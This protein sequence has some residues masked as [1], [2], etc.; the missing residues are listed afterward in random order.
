[1][2]KYFIKSQNMCSK[3]RNA[4][5]VSEI[6]ASKLMTSLFN[7]FTVVS[8]RHSSMFYDHSNN[9]ANIIEMTIEL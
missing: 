2:Q 7:F 5:W 6:L 1:M 8:V 4:E 9:V 3:K